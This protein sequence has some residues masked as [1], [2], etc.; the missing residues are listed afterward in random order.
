MSTQE[1]PIH[2]FCLCVADD[3]GKSVS[4]LLWTHFSPVKAIHWIPYFSISRLHSTHGIDTPITPSFLG[5]HTTKSPYLRWSQLG[6][7]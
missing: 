7:S 2:L 4:R 1:K 3:F 5:R 6:K